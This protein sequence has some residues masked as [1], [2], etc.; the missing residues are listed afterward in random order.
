MYYKTIYNAI[1]VPRFLRSS[2][3][4]ASSAKSTSPSSFSGRV[5][6]DAEGFG[7]IQK[8]LVGAFDHVMGQ[9]SQLCSLIGRTDVMVH[10]GRRRHRAGRM[11]CARELATAADGLGV[12]RLAE[13]Y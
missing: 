7:V 8:A 9:R 10:R 3:L 13:H 5:S 11:E 4:W 2:A 6:V 1:T 12:T